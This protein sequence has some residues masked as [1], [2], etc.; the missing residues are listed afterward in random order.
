[1]HGKPNRTNQSTDWYVECRSIVFI[2][3]I[4][5]PG[6]Y[7]VYAVWHVGRCPS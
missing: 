3:E 2:D 6:L 5:A 1:M 4:M 7:K